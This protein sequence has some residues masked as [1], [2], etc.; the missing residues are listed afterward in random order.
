MAFQDLLGQAAPGLG[1]LLGGGIGLGLGG[2]AGAGLGTQLGALGGDLLSQFIPKT[3]SPFQKQAREAQSTLLQQLSQQKPFQ[4]VDFDPIRQQEISR[5]N[6][7]ILPEIAQRFGSSTGQTGV[8]QKSLGEAGA[9]LA[10]RLAALQ[11]QH[12]IGQQEAQLASQGQDINRLGQLQSFLQGNTLQ[13]SQ[14][15]ANRLGQLG[16]LLSLGRQIGDQ[17]IDQQRRTNEQ[18]GG[19]YDRAGQYGSGTPGEAP[20]GLGQGLLGGGVKAFEA[21]LKAYLRGGL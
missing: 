13:A 7:D 11:S 16:N 20:P 3:E 5:F 6:Q 8:F 18:L 10:E 9:G 2:P 12:D 1:S 21:A 17:Q 4:K 19:Y 15:S 14:E